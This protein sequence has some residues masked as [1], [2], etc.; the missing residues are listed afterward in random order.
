MRYRDSMNRCILEGGP[1]SRANL[2]YRRI[3]RYGHAWSKRKGVS[4]FDWPQAVIRVTWLLTHDSS[5]CN[6]DNNEY[7][8]VSVP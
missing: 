8:N 1:F 6:S 5:F 7:T 3:T 4:S 2:L